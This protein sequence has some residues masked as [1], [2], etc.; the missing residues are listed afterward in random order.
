VSQ[1]AKRLVIR[2]SA[3]GKLMLLGEH[4]VVHGRSCLVT[5]MNAR[6]Y[7][8][9]TLADPGDDTFTIHAPD[10]GVEGITGRSADA[11]AGGRAL[12]RGTRF[13]ESALAVFRE[14]FGLDR[15]VRIETR[16]DFSSQLGLGSSSATVACALFGLAHLF[17]VEIEPRDLFDLGF[18]AIFRVQQTGSGF[19]L[20]A[21]IFGGTLFYDNGHPRQIV[22]LDVPDLPLIVAYT[23]IKADTITVVNRVS[24][25]LASWPSAINGIFDTMAQL[26]LDG[27][28]ALENRD[29]TRL[30]QLMD[31][32][33]GLA[34]AIGVDT[35][36]T[37]LLVFRARAAGAYGAK[38]S[39][40]GGGDCI[41][42]LAPDDRRAAM[43][44][45]LEAAG[46]EIVRV[47][48][49]APGVRL[50][51][52]GGSHVHQQSHCD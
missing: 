6:L 1:A 39:G 23:G 2:V 37:V 32:Q 11:F 3:P 36:E 24:A 43:E 44:T 45:A 18:E 13:I 19:D 5:A 34:H 22:P 52:E 33:H 50:E 30:G 17:Q 49:H 14:Q 21:A 25:L 35:P 9:L 7:M 51:S 12:A 48:P 46:S 10:V 40:A 15:G 31:I 8:T 47:A 42:V 29:W 27:R 26:V 16:S 38:L 20:A 28:I 41:I 4:A